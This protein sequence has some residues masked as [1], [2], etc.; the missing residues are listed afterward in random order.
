MK[1]EMQ[2]MM[3]KKRAV[4]AVIVTFIVAGTT[5]FGILMYLDRRDYRVFLTNQYSKNLYNVISNVEGI[6]VALSKIPVSSTKEENLLIFGQIWKQASTAQDELSSLPVS[7]GSTSETTKFLSQVGDFSYALLKSNNKGENLSKN[8]IDTVNKLRQNVNMLDGELHNLQGT[9]ASGNIDW[10]EIK[11]K[12]R[13]L[14]KR[15]AANNVN[16]KF[17]KMAQDMQQYPTLIYDGPFSENV[18]NIQPKVLSE[19]KITVDEAK[20]V[21]RGIYGSDKIASMT[22]STGKSGAKIPAYSFA[23]K[24]KGREN[25]PVSI[26]ISANGGHIIYILDN[27]SIG[28]SKLDM[29]ASVKK[30][31]DYLTSKGYKNMLPTYTLQY[32]NIVVVNYV[33]IDNKTVVYPDQI[34]LKIAMDN[35][36]IVGFEGEKYLTSHYTRSIKTPK[37]SVNAAKRAVSKNITIQNV[38]LTIIPSDSF[39]EIVCYEFYGTYNNEKYITYINADDGTVEKIL[40]IINTPNGELTM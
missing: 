1:K 28:N 40:K 20:N 26:N 14:F 36:D 17:E 38:R 18:L 35:G 8:E 24:L 7:Q 10:G 5:T 29:K 13:S 9:I 27:R 16:V 33:Y 32:N 22:Q 30:G 6:D 34:K 2:I 23:V 12:G 21:V 19:K 39:R 3:F 11:N 15:T 37:V 25:S 4:L 31:L